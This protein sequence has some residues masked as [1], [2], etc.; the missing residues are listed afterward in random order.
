MEIRKFGHSCMLV[1][2]EGV[3]ILIDPGS[4]S[5]GFESLSELDG[6]LLT[7]QHIDHFDKDRI[8]QLL[9]SNDR[10]EVIADEQTAELLSDAATVRAV[11]ED[12][13]FSMGPL[14]IT[15]HGREHVVIHPDLP[16]VTNVG[17]FIA[18]TVFHPGDALTVPERPVNVLA[19]PVG[20]PWLR[21][22]DAIDYLRA[23]RPAVAIAIHE[24]ALGSPAMVYG[25]IGRFAAEQGTR[26]VVLDGDDSLTV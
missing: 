4:Y 2:A 12:D 15:V 1:E 18:D 22:R 7:H 6:L 26:F 10:A 23:V 5:T 20:A 21:V 14:G 17:Y 9:T 3:R 19:L 13:Q 11:H 16:N 8:L 25:L 24:R